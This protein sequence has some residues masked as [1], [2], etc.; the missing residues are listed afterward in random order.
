MGAKS[1][2]VSFLK[3]E[4]GVGKWENREAGKRTNSDVALF[5][6]P[7]IATAGVYAKDRGRAEAKPSEVKRDPLKW[8]SHYPESKS[9]IYNI[10][11]NYLYR[12]I[13]NAA[14]EL[15]CGKSPGC[16]GMLQYYEI[17]T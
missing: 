7:P 2:R 15:E 8:T 17:G 3:E 5:T 10:H 4:V 16:G 9:S 1:F 12:D 6:F 13:K 11:G 14:F